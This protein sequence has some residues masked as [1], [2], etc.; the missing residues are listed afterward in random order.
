MPSGSCISD[1]GIGIRSDKVMLA[2]ARAAV[3][4]AGK[5]EETAAG[6]RG[7]PAAVA[8]R[9]SVLAAGEVEV[10]AQAVAAQS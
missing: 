3:V 1:G 2:A 5:V 8:T 7:D 10:A 9:A 6:L 4:A